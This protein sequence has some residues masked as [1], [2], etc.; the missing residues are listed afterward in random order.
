MLANKCLIYRCLA[1][2]VLISGCT[3]VPKDGGI[4]PVSELVTARID[5]TVQ[6]P[7]SGAE[8]QFS[9]AQ[10]TQMISAPLN[11]LDA[12]RLSVAV[13]PMLRVKLA[14]VGVA[15]ADY[16]QAGRMENPGFTYERY[17]GDEYSA[18]LLFDIGG[19][20]LMPLK[21][22]MYARRLETARYQAAG[23]VLQHVAGTRNLW[24]KAV[25]EKQQTVAMARALESAAAGNNLTRQMAALGHSS[26]MDAADSEIFLSEMRTAL[27]RQRLAEAGAREA[28]VRQLGLWGSQAQQLALPERLPGLPQQPLEIESVEQQAMEKRM[29]VRMANLNIEAMAE[30]LK[31]TRYNP[32]LSSI[33]LGPTL[34][35][36]G[37]ETERGFEL[38]WRIPIFD[39]GGIK[40]AK[41]RII[42]EQAQAQAQVTAIVAVS[43]ARQA[44]QGYHSSFDIAQ[45][46]RDVVMPLR[47][48][49]TEEQML[50][51]NGMLISVFD[52]LDDLRKS[53]ALESTYINAVRDFWL[54][55]ADL[56]QALT[57]SGLVAMNFE[58]SSTMPGSAADGAGH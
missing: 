6:L 44:L 18:S 32:F 57:G 17:A 15:E 55:D 28:L 52:L 48:R 56:Q 39:A 12:E 23:E 4:E 31:L 46:Y 42:Y 11:M 3:S 24:I 21:R 33:E 37:S 5:P 47:Q 51:Y 10:V 1:T 49:V 45:Q 50:L 7:V 13:N 27:T 20:V 35:R 14:Q 19:L 8:P 54:A 43:N 38:E 26:V 16:A 36:S 58:A 9:R 30:N 34:E 40:T 25:A 53:I 2:L 22:E 29:D 41:A